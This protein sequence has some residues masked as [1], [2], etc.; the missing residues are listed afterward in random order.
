M[1][2]PLHKVFFR[3]LT[4]WICLVLLCVF[5]KVYSQ[6]PIDKWIEKGESARLDQSYPEAIKYFEWAMRKESDP[7]PYIGLGKCYRSLRDYQNAAKYFGK[8]ADYPD[9]NTEVYFFLAQSLL[10]IGD[11]KGAEKWFQIYSENTPD[12]EQVVKWK[13]L[14]ALFEKE[15]PDSTQLEVTRFPYNTSSSDFSAVPIGTSLYFC[16]S[17]KTKS[18]IVHVSTLNDAP[19]IDLYKVDDYFN[20]DE[21]QKPPKPLTDLNSRFNEGPMCFSSDEKTIYFTRN[22]SELKRA[23]ESRVSLN[24]LRIYKSVYEG[25]HWTEGESL[26]FN[27]DDYAVGHPSLSPD[28]SRL[29]FVSDMPGGQGGTDVYYVDILPGGGYGIPKNLGSKVNSPGDEMF[30]FIAGDGA[31]YFASDNHLGFGGLD[32][33]KSIPI[34][35]IGWS[36]PYNLGPPINSQ[37]DDFAYLLYA[38]GKTGLFSSNRGKSHEDD[39]IYEFRIA[40]SHF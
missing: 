30:P 5:G 38:D 1:S 16:S 13:D 32:I 19:L 10:A 25:D 26:P 11:K 8:A 28:N 4:G 14:R 24:K 23:R 18:S 33:F 20:P 12:E 3:S 39:D 37:E 29:Y 22:N 7:R 2:D 21:R 36:I 40:A 34:G 6:Q 35:S 15:Q 17:R 9:V 31:L 27:N